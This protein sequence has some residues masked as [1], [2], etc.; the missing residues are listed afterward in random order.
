VTRLGT[1][2]RIRHYMT[3]QLLC[4]VLVSTLIAFSAARSDG[5]PLSRARTRAGYALA[6]DLQFADCY[7]TLHDWGGP[8]FG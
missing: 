3:R 8:A 2:L 1:P 4:A 7:N 5:S 6:Y